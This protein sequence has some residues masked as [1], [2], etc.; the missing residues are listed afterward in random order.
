LFYELT[1][2][3]SSELA[4]LD[5]VPEKRLMPTTDVLVI[6]AGIAG[7]S[8]AYEL[9]P[10]ARVIL[11][12][13]ERQPGYH[14]TGR[15]AAVF[16]PTDGNRV[17]RALTSA[18]RAFYEARA[19]GLAEQPVM[20]PR[21]ELIIAREDQMAAL[22]AY[23]AAS[24]GQVSAL[25][26]LDS[27]QACEKVPI[28]RADYIAGA[29]HDPGTMDLDVAAIHQGYLKGM[30]SRGGTLI[31]DAEV[32]AIAPD[33]PPWQVETRN[34]TYQAAVLVDAAG[35]WAD[36]LAAMAGVRPLGLV[37]KRRT[38]ILMEPSA[39]ADPAWPIVFD[40]GEQFYF[41]PESGQ[42]LGSP[43]DQTPMPPCDVQP[44]ELD[45]ALAVDRI[46]RATTIDVRRITHKWAGLRTFA[47]DST[48]VVGMDQPGFFWLA[49]QGGYGIQTAPAMA[50]AATSLLIEGVLP[51]DLTAQ[52]LKP[53][54]LSPARFRPAAE[55]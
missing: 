40:V 25:Q 3:L 43:A 37:P 20:T 31:T 19:G 23:H 7:A 29:I 28:L 22:D 27:H 2:D 9:V 42:L 26:R 44:D 6:G 32:A 39:A 41:K 55:G 50:R 24:I 8:V 53:E 52:G 34:A 4:L 14:T 18:S 36:Q 17:I 48:P 12:E 47:A 13:R 1:C 33:G 54:D 21:G 5:A 11:L 10:F 45:I 51:D 15:S 49:G 46:E 16:S 35:A 30:R 38:A